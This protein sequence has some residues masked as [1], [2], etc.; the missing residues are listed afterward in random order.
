[1]PEDLTQLIDR[2]QRDAVEEAERQSAEMVAGAR[3]KA[4]AIVGEAEKKA[5]ALQEKAEKD[6]E[7]FALRG[8][9]SLEQAA[10][11]LIIAVGQGVERILRTIV[12]EAVDEAMDIATVR[13]M[14]LRIAAA[15]VEAKG[16]KRME[17]LVSPSDQAEMVKFFAAKYREGL[18]RGVELRADGDVLKGFRVAFKDDYV[19]L[20][21]TNEAVADA[22]ARYLQP[23]LAAIV[24]RAADVKATIADVCRD[25]SAGGQEIGTP[26]RTSPG[27]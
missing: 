22:L 14:L 11:D 21:F 17:L 3:R 7:V 2:I 20:D 9:R 4:A 26:S 24:G 18:V 1:M 27:K 13:E 15:Y 5:A 25:I 10:R 19:Y 16:D 8:E 6:A 23:H 12:D